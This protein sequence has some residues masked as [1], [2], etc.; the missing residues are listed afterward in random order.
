MA[1]GR[2]EFCG[3]IRN[4][5]VCSEKVESFSHVGVRSSGLKKSSIWHYAVPCGHHVEISAQ[6]SGGTAS[7]TGLAKYKGGPVWKNGYR[8]VNVFWGPYWKSSSWVERLNKAVQDIEDN[9]SYSG[10]LSQYGVGTGTLSGHAVVEQDPPKTVSEKD[11]GDAIRS[12]ISNSTVVDVGSSGA[13][14]VF[15]PPGVTAT[16][17]SDQSCAKFCDYHDTANGDQGPFFTCEPYPCGTGCNQCDSNEFDTLTQG[18]SEEMVELKTDMN[19]GT[20]WVIGNEEICDYCDS[21]FVCNRISTGEYVNAWYS[22]S[23]GACWTPG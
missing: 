18:L 20:G 9:S 21:N 10:E 7:T 17:G 14:N 2:C 8:W 4:C 6:G 3:E 5:P 11:I 12:W 22:D 19:P 1:I 16:L 23:K 13:Y 15:L